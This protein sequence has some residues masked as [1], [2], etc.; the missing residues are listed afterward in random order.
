MNFHKNNLGAGAPNLG[1][2]AIK[3]MLDEENLTLRRPRVLEEVSHQS[4]T[5]RCFQVHISIYYYLT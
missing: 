1:D 2:K 3:R 4:W 5:F